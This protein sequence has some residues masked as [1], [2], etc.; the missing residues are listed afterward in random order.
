MPTIATCPSALPCHVE[1]PNKGFWCVYPHYHSTNHSLAATTP[2]PWKQG[3][4]PLAATT[5]CPENEHEGLFSGLGAEISWC[6][7]SAQYN[8]HIN[9]STYDDQWK[10]DCWDRPQYCMF[11]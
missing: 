1:S 3:N 11:F 5:N 10:M 7:G 8:L 9:S 6:P 4:H 2:Q